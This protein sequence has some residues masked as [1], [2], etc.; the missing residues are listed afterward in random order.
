MKA[1]VL[2]T[3]GEWA[4]VLRDDGV[5]EKIRRQ[6][7]VGDTI[8]ISVGKTIQFPG[9]FAKMTAAAA[10]AVIILTGGGLYGYNNAYAYSYVTLDANPSIEYVLNRKNELLK[11]SA[12]NEEAEE[13]VRA[14]T[15]E[16]IRGESLSQIVGQ[17]TEL[18]RENEYLED[19]DNVLL[20]SITSKG[21]KQAQELLGEVDA[22]TSS[23]DDEL[24]VYV[25][26]A[27]SEDASEARRLGVSTGRYKIASEETAVSDG[28]AERISR[29]TVRELIGG[30]Q[31][32]T[33]DVLPEAR[34]A[35]LPAQESARPGR[36]ADT[37]P[38]TGAQNESTGSRTADEGPETAVP[39]TGESI[40]RTDGS[41]EPDTGTAAGPQAG[42]GTGEPGR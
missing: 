41:A 14:L 4:A 22:F 30:P 1:V 19:E 36:S 8:E 2:E 40:S 18:L 37:L 11:V 27:S 35:E 33:T 7:S 28:D 13:I 29:T 3:R 15:E 6:C 25:T 16:N 39:D 10:A 38:D 5:V 9:R 24:E 17:T 12:L 31:A 21:E 23:V 26:E 34:E 32:V 42:S 20:I